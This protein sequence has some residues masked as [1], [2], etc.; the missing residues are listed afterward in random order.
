MELKSV[1]VESGPDDVVGK[2]TKRS[3]VKTGNK[4]KV[5]RRSY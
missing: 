3:K 5:R 4:E 1:V 2:L